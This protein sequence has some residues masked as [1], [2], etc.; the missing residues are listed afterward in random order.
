[1]FFFFLHSVQPRGVLK[2]VDGEE[3]DMNNTD[4]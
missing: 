1:M 2:G 4:L 3:S